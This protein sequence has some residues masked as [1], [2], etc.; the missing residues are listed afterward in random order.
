MSKR[1]ASSTGRRDRVKPR[2]TGESARS[3]PAGPRVSARPPGEIPHPA[4]TEAP[5]LGPAPSPPPLHALLV[6]GDAVFGEDLALLAHDAGLAPVV[7]LTLAGAREQLRQRPWDL[8]LVEPNLPDGSGLPL[9]TEVRALA[10]RTLV[11]VVAEEFRVDELR[12]ALNA[13]AGAILPRSAPGGQL[14]VAIRRAAS[15]VKVDSFRRQIEARYRQ[16]FDRGLDAAYLIDREGRIVEAN[17]AAGRAPSLGTPTAGGEEFVDL[18]PREARRP[19]SD[20]LA[21][22]DPAGAEGAAAPVLELE[23]DSDGG[24]VVLELRGWPV[25]GTVPALRHVVVR[26]V[27]ERARLAERA[28]RAERLA[29]VGRFAADLA[30]ELRNALAGIDGVLQVLQHDASLP[31]SRQEIVGEARRR[32]GRTRE[33]VAE[34]LAYMRPLRLVRHAW[35]VPEVLDAIRESVLGHPELAGVEVRIVDGCP[36]DLAVEIDASHLRLAARNLILNAAQAMGGRGEI[37][38]T[39]ALRGAEVQLA[40]EDDGPGVPP[41]IAP[42]IFEPFFTTRAEGTGL[43]LAI[44]SSIVES[45]G[46]RLFLDRSRRGARFVVALPAAAGRGRRRATRSAKGIADAD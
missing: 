23:V 5:S 24:P 34:L 36:S 8:M 27:T 22:L 7:V 17:L 20:W 41:E 26:D 31:A 45:H 28:L 16:V 42:R 18:W 35:P 40:F 44:A 15:L 14:A 2:R 12:L 33:V 6:T 11:I 1:R 32:I 46:G 39:G 25:P 4:T 9:L 19:V 37:V 3:A 38:V 13:G 10:L 43:G 21:G 30:H 29:G